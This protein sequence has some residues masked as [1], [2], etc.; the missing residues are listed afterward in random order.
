MVFSKHK[1][2]DVPDWKSKLDIKTFLMP[3][4]KSSDTKMPDCRLDLVERYHSF[5]ENTKLGG[6][7][8]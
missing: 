8:E 6:V 4:K 5:M 1:G 7:I 2:K 3:L